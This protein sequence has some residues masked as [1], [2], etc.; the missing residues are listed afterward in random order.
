V[1]RRFT[2][3]AVTLSG[4]SSFGFK[5]GARGARGVLAEKIKFSEIH[6]RVESK[7]QKRVPAKTLSL[8]NAA[9]EIVPLVTVNEFA[10]AAG[11]NTKKGIGAYT[12]PD[13][14]RTCRDVRLDG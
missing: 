9:K 3:E 1:I 14:L 13:D 11:G 5:A 6:G 10:S 8:P 12:T 7:A 2:A 4:S